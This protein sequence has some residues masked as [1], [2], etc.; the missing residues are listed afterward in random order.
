MFQENAKI[1]ALT[2]VAVGIMELSLTASKI[3]RHILPGQFLNIRVND[4]LQPLLR[5]PFSV[6]T[7]KGDTLSIIF[8]VIGAGTRA[9]SHH[10]IGDC[11]DLIGPLGNGFMPALTM[12]EYE[13]VVI[14][15]GGM[16]IAPFPFVT[17][18]IQTGKKIITF[19]GARNKRAVIREGLQNIRIATDDGSEG[20]HGNVVEAVKSYFAQNAIERPIFLTCGPMKM[21]TALAGFATE[22]NIPC[23]ASLECD[24]A[25][26]IGLCQGCPVETVDS[27]KRYALV[28]KEG[29]VFETRT[30]LI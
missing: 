10:S 3:T 1:S 25:C 16:G 21:M 26:G 28:C 19:I 20:H 2:E 13:T 9:L 15:A 8:N 14:V 17:S 4:S 11:L 5:R 6:F 18:M 12:T 29:P 27:G 24:M 23:F 22:N 30:I 7:V